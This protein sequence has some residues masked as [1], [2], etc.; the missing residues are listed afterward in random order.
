M[1]SV[2]KLVSFVPSASE[3]EDLPPERPTHGTFSYW[4]RMV[5]VVSSYLELVRI[6]S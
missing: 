2:P 6:R 5:H 1:P 4:S 3:P